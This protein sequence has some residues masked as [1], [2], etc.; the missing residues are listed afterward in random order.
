MQEHRAMKAR[1]VACTQEGRSW[2]K[3]VAQ[4]GGS[5]STSR[6]AREGCG[7]KPWQR[8]MKYHRCLVSFHAYEETHLNQYAEYDIPLFGPT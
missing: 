7:V 1:L 8:F 3:A 6:Y 5:H 4:I 2:R